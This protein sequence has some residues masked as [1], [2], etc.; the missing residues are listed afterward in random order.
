MSKRA[1][2]DEIRKPSN[3]FWF[4]YILELNNG[5]FYTSTRMNLIKEFTGIRMENETIKEMVYKLGADVCGIVTIERF[6]NAP[7]GFH[8]NDILSDRLDDT[9]FP[10]FELFDL[11]NYYKE[12][13]WPAIFTKRGCVFHCTY[14][15]YSSLEGNYYREK[16]PGRVV[17]EIEHI[18]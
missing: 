7:S 5:K 18:S 8:P 9:A 6:Q 10:A 13:I 2:A 15:P 17:D 16:S 12:N 3:Q 1:S 11:D 4:V 14:C